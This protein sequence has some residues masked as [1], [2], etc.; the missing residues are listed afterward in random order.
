M[1]RLAATDAQLH[2]DEAMLEIKTQRNERKPLGLAFEPQFLDLPLLLLSCRA[3]LLDLRLEAVE[4]LLLTLLALLLL[5]LAI[6]QIR[7][8]GPRTRTR[9]RFSLRLHEGHL[10]NTY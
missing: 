2:L 3:L 6:S 9:K 4:L 1:L 5:L 7:T 8:L 10:T